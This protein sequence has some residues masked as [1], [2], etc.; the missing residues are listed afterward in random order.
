MIKYTYSLEKIYSDKF[1]L[2]HHL[3]LGDHI[4]CNGLL[5]RISQ[6]YEKIYLPAK[7]NNFE[8]I[9]YM[10]RDNKKIEVFFTGSKNEKDD[11]IKFAKESNYKIL[12]VGFNKIKPPF[13]KSFYDQLD[14]PYSISFDFFR[15]PNETNQFEELEK[16]LKNFYEVKDSF[17]LIHSEG[18]LGKV[19]LKMKDSKNNIFVEKESDKF[20]NIFLYINLI[21]KAKEIHCIDSSFIHLV[22]RIETN[23]KLYF[24][25]LKTNTQDSANILLSKNWIKIKYF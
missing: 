1:I 3:G 25:E 18:S 4:I 2:W 23:A 7:P 9:K 6:N 8:S 20:K 11:I 14:L 22:E 19:N 12:K 15:I 17:N 10:F 5:N 13:N 24:H 16:H 21:K